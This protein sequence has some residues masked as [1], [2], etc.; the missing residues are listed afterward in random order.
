MEF[1]LRL[2]RSPVPSSVGRRFQFDGD[3]EMR[4]FRMGCVR[5]CA[6][7]AV[8]VVVSASSADVLN[9]SYSNGFENG[10]SGSFYG[11]AFATDWGGN[12]D[13]QL[14]S[15]YQPGSNG[16]W[17]SPQINADI[18]SFHATFKFSY[19]HNG[20]GHLGDGFSFLFGDL[21]DMDNDRWLGGEGGIKAF[22]DDGAGMSVGF[23]S[24]GGGND[25]GIFARWGSDVRAAN[26]GV[27][28]DEFGRASYDNYGQAL[29]DYFQG[30]IEID[31]NNDTGL[32]V[33]VSWPAW[34]METYISTGEFTNLD[35]D[36]FNFGFTARNGGIDHDVLIDGFNVDYTYIPSPGA[37]GLMVLG[38]FARRRRR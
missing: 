13:L 11:A 30:T 18:Q 37:L 25:S 23:D 22:S 2:R 12:S 20:N 26:T 35:L 7:G 28:P 1:P 34:G 33:G 31:W 36:S 16:T 21:S 17:I 38:G 5:A 15:D 24:Y 4:L 29:D 19:N 14:V 10:D 9:G 6:V 3:I 8:G 32:T 27:G